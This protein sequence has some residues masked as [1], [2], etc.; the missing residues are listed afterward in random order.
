MTTKPREVVA[1]STTRESTSRKVTPLK[2]QEH[3]E[4]ARVTTIKTGG[5]IRL[6]AKTPTVVNVMDVQPD[7][8][9]T[10]VTQRTAR[11]KTSRPNPKPD[12]P[13][14]KRDGES[15]PVSPSCKAPTVS[16]P[17][18]HL[19][20]P[21]STPS[22]FRGS[23]IPRARRSSGDVPLEWDGRSVVCCNVWKLL[24]YDTRSP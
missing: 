9:I 11:D 3:Q 7:A 23:T 2:N 24:P 12:S 13:P 1:I 20:H 17:H 14:R 6:Q 18:I 19:R 16:N 5:V 4:A 21:P 22:L 8:S 10:R 15:P